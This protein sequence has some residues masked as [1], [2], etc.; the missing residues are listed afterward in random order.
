M[1]MGSRQMRRRRRA[2]SER[3]RR[4]RNANAVLFEIVGAVH[5]SAK[6]VEWPV[7][8]FT[9]LATLVG[10]VVSLLTGAF[11]LAAGLFVSSVVLCGVLWARE[12]S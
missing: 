1:S 12:L 7:L 11:V 10:A 2:R 8:F 3:A 5:A 9:M 6:K 4:R